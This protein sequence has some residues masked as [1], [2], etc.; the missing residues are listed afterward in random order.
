MAT[1]EKIYHLG[2]DELI[3]PSFMSSTLDF[4][5][6]CHTA[7]YSDGAMEFSLHEGFQLEMVSVYPRESE[8]LLPPNNVD[9]RSS[10][11]MVKRVARPHGEEDPPNKN[12]KIPRTPTTTANKFE[13]L[14][15][16]R[17]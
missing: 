2:G 13:Q 9:K 6:A 3:F 5:A 12:A 8:V 17:S 1:L 14:T 7:G 16:G 10:A 4:K 11:P 15:D